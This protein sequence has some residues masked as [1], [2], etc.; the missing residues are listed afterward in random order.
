MEK[1]ICLDA[2]IL[3][4]YYSTDENRGGVDCLFDIIKDEGLMICVPA[5]SH[6]EFSNAMAKKQKRAVMLPLEV[7][8]ATENLFKLPIIMY[9]NIDLIKRTH[10]LCEQG[11]P[12][13]YDATYVATAMLNHIPLVT[14]DKELS[15]KAR[16]IYPGVFT[17]DE[18]VGSLN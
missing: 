17:T 11:L 3:T 15:K 2:N 16:K 10:S 18:W 12:S 5:L 4:R 6:F 1:S 9:W 8:E 14:E 13:F 7:K